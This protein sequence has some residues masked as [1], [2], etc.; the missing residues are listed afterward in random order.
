MHYISVILA[1]IRK[2]IPILY[3]PIHTYLLFLKKSAFTH[4]A[5]K[6][7]IYAIHTS[8]TSL[9][10]NQTVYLYMLFILIQIA[11]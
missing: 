5:L 2:S 9:T 3:L 7:L 8:V 10:T 6:A 1:C 4:F 11:L